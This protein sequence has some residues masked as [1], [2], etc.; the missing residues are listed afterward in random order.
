MF[1]SINEHLRNHFYN[2]PEIDA[3]LKINE[4]KVLDNKLSSFIAARNVLDF[5]FKKTNL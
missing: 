3:M 4:A 1:E 2:D 5:Y